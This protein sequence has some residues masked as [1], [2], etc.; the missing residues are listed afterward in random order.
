MNQLDESDRFDFYEELLP[1]D[2]WMPEE[3]DGNYVV[4][5]VLDNIFSMSTNTDSR[6]QHL[7][8]KWAGYD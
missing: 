6:Q 5:A 7:L 8:V 1:E 2:I 4:K 3:T